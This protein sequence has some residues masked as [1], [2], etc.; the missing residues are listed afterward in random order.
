MV[1]PENVLAEKWLP[2]FDILGHENVKL[3]ITHGG[4]AGLQ[5]GLY[6]KKPMIV[7]PVFGDQYVNAFKVVDA[8]IGR[9][10]NVHKITTERVMFEIKSVIKNSSYYENI[11]ML[12]EAFTNGSVNPLDNALFW[13]E[14]VM[15]FKSAKYFTPSAPYVGWYEYLYLDFLCIFYVFYLFISFFVRKCCWICLRR[16][17]PETIDKNLLKKKRK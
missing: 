15:K 16:R 2:Q 4:N 3:F 5:E 11:E 7:I 10:L 13:I 6:H 12:S 14:H 9:Y 1:F 8:G 17:K